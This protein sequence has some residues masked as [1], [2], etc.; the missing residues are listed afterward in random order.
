[1]SVTSSIMTGNG[2]SSATKRIIGAVPPKNG[3]AAPALQQFLYGTINYGSRNCDDSTV[4]GDGYDALPP[5]PSSMFLPPRNMP[6]E[7]YD[8]EDAVSYLAEAMKHAQN[9]NDDEDSVLLL[10]TPKDDGTGEEICQVISAMDG[11]PLPVREIIE[12]SSGNNSYEDADDVANQ[13]SDVKP[14]NLA[15]LFTDEKAPI[16]IMDAVE[17][18]GELILT[19]QNLNPHNDRANIFRCS[20][21]EAGVNLLPGSIIDSEDEDETLVYHDGCTVIQ[22]SSTFGDNTIAT[23]TTSPKQEEAAILTTPDGLP[24][25]RQAAKNGSFLFSP[26]N[27]GRANPIIRAK[28]RASLKDGKRVKPSIT[29]LPPSAMTNKSANE[30]VADEKALVIR[31]SYSYSS[32]L[33]TSDESVTLAAI[34]AEEEEEVENYADANHQVMASMTEDRQFSFQSILNQFSTDASCDGSLQKPLFH[35]EE[36]HAPASPEVSKTREDVMKTPVVA[37]TKTYPKTPFPEAEITA[38]DAVASPAIVV[39]LNTTSNFSPSSASIASFKS[40]NKGG[41]GSRKKPSPKYKSVPKSAVKTKKGYVK[42]RV[43]DIHQLIDVTS[44]VSN[45]NNNGAMTGGRLKR[46]HSYRLKS[47]RRMTNGNGVLAPKHAVLQSTYIRSVPIGIAKTYSRDSIGNSFSHEENSN[48]VYEEE[49]NVHEEEEEENSVSY[50]FKYTAEPA[51]VVKQAEQPI[52]NAV[53]QAVSFDKSSP[54]SVKAGGSFSDASSYVSE[55]TDC[56]PFNSLLGKMTSEDEESS[57]DDGSQ[58]SSDQGEEREGAYGE[59]DGSDKENNADTNNNPS[60]SSAHLPFKIT[61]LVKPT[62]L[63]QH[64]RNNDDHRAPL[65]PVPMPAQ[66]WRTMAAAAAEK[67]SQNQTSARFRTE[68][69]W[70]EISR[71]D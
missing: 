43:S 9:S 17:V 12:A 61:T 2:S 68:K 8:E 66:T 41:G 36:G 51:N 40:A 62:E 56:D 7:E 48:S 50:A 14:H 15:C 71:H 28:E 49:E 5:P 47:T 3:E 29:M 34:K 26:D 38:D 30:V 64:H 32:N 39:A 57:S 67:K 37:M 22:N 42:D 19:P 23:M 45:S 21:S 59:E 60:S 46:N 16:Q 20:T 70:R 63:H 24:L 69:S 33:Q 6:D 13:H 55:T 4:D 10:V 54:E 58:V 35:G 65:S 52:N 31:Q 53:K 1:M 27:M 25:T 11:T 18:D 44:T